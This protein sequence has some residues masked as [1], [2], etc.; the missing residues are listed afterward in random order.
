MGVGVGA[1]EAVG[2]GIVSRGVAVADVHA[3]M[4]ADTATATP[5]AL[6]RR[7][8]NPGIVGMEDRRILING[9][10]QRRSLLNISYAAAN[11]PDAYVGLSG[12]SSGP[13]V[14][15]HESP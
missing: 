7:T 13:P 10:G 1:G 6:W 14:G 2:T 15:R 9:L 5:I 11:P 4:N 8:E 12:F 3:T